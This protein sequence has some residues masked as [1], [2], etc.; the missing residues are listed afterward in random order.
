MG[1][2][3]RRIAKGSMWLSA[4]QLVSTAIAFA[5]SIL[6]ARLL[7]P[8]EYGLI[9]VALTF[10]GLLLGLL[11]LGISDVIVRFAPLDNRGKGCVS[12]MLLSKTATAVVASLLVFTLRTTWLELSIDPT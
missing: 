10:S 4:G 7:T 11:D 6:I 5:G 3:G 12:T 1:L 9:S 2:A 8:G